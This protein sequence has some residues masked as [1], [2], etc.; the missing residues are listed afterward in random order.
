MVVEFTTTYAIST[1]HHKSCEFEPRSWRGVLDTT[2]CD[3]VC[4]W[5]LRFPPPKK[6]DRHDITEI[7]LKVALNTINIAKPI[8]RSIS[9]IHIFFQWLVSYNQHVADVYLLKYLSANYRHSAFVLTMIILISVR[10][11]G[12]LLSLCQ[13]KRCLDYY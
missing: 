6:T 10:H 12:G 4:L 1:Y 13:S 7:L 2:F 11:Y 8:I 5:V 3:N 9:D